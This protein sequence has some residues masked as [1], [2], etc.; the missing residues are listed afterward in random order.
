MPGRPGNAEPQ[1]GIIP[2]FAELGLGVPGKNMLQGYPITGWDRVIV[3]HRQRV[4]NLP[5]CSPLY[6]LDLPYYPLCY[7]LHKTIKHVLRIAK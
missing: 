3:T 5:D 2:H 7:L 4:S 6:D 1:L